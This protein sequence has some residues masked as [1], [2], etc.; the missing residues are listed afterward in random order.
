NLA[1]WRPATATCPRL[2]PPPRH[3]H[4]GEPRHRPGRAGRGRGDD[5][6]QE[7]GRSMT[8]APKRRTKT[9]APGVFRSSSG[10]YEI[11]YRDSDGTLRSK[12]AGN[13]F[14][15]AKATRAD[16]VSKMAKGERVSRT[17][18]VFRD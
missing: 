18:V 9:R 11:V 13:D 16:L 4:S 6:T 10:A 12:V 14:E 7:R 17:K 15:A 3:E 1:R 5:E 8:T 2:R